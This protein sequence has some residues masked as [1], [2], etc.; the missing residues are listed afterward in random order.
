M[1][2]RSRPPAVTAEPCG[3]TRA[4]ILV[5]SGLLDVAAGISDLASSLTDSALRS[6]QTRIS[7]RGRAASLDNTDFLRAAIFQGLAENIME[8]VEL[9]L[10]A[11][12]LQSNAVVEKLAERP[13]QSKM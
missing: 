11:E 9:R 6:I 1:S 2:T 10:K 8:R 3:P 12:L 13:L 7:E 4:Q 5:Q